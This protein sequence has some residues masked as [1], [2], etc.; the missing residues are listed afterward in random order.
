MSRE[1]DIGYCETCHKQFGYYL[2]HNGF[3][4]SAYAYCDTCGEA[5]LLNLWHLPKGVEIK[6]YGVIPESVEPFLKS[7]ECRGTFRK[8]AS[9]RCSHCNSILSPIE[10]TKYIEANAPA[11][12]DGWRWQ[13]SW[14]GLYCIII[15]DKVAHD[16]WK[17]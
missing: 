17:E 8:G 6:D 2:I 14:E 5:C 13:Q 3:N 15:E 12:K 7:C 1:K 10:A 4:D 16:C 11:A 9:P